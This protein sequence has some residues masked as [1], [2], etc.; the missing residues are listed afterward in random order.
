M[1]FTKIY[2]ITH[3]YIYTCIYLYNIFGKEPEAS[4]G[5]LKV[6]QFGSPFGS[7]FSH[8]ARSKKDFL[9]AAKVAIIEATIHVRLARAKSGEREVGAVSA[10]PGG[11]LKNLAQ[12]MG[13]PTG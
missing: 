13:Q 7:P 9:W 5:I 3:I 8:Q 2:N 11:K 4:K 10:Q 6:P 1:S 12:H